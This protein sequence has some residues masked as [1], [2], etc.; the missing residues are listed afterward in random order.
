MNRSQTAYKSYG[1][2]VRT[3]IR[4]GQETLGCLCQNSKGVPTIPCACPDPEPDRPR[5]SKSG[6]LLG[7]I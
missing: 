7:W 4:A 1:F 5:E 3:G 6:G 2:R